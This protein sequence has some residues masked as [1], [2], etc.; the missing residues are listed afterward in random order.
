MTPPV[1]STTKP[2]DAE[3]RALLREVIHRQAPELLPMLPRAELNVLL[4]DER[5]RLCQLITTEFMQS[6]IGPDYEPLPRG[7]KLE[8]LLDTIN[9]PNL[10]RK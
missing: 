4:P 1:R 7:R 8:S 3:E 5:T 10:V 2:L 9:R 6:G